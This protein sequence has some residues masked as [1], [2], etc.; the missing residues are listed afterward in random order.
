MLLISALLVRM[1]QCFEARCKQIGPRRRE[2]CVV[3]LVASSRK[4]HPNS[5]APRKEF[6]ARGEWVCIIEIIQN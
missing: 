4:H 2:G 6:K 5:L 1:K 3:V